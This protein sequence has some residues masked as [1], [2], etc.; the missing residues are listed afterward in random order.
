MFVKWKQCS[1]DKA[2]DQWSGFGMAV[3]ASIIISNCR[4]FPLPSLHHHLPLSEINRV[5]LLAAAHG[6]SAIMLFAVFYESE[7][8]CESDHSLLKIFCS[9]GFCDAHC[10]LILHIPL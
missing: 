5:L 4:K 2:T 8:F 3:T 10:F 6:L 9:F 7:V 1:L